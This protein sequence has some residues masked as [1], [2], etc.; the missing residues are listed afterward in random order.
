MAWDFETDREYQEKLDWADTFLREE[1][2]P[3]D[4]VVSATDIHN[5]LWQEVVPALQAKVKAQ[6]LWATHLGPELGGPGFGQ[7]KLALLN[8]ILGRS[9]LGPTVFGCAAPDTGNMEILAHYGTA[10]QKERWLKPLLDGEILSAYS[11]TEPQGGAD[12]TALLTTAELDGDEWVI[13]GEKWFTT[14][15][16]QAEFL[17]M[18]VVTDP[19]RC[20]SFRWTP[21]ASK[22]SGTSA[23]GGGPIVKAPRPT[24]G[25]ST[26]GYRGRIF[27]VSRARRLP[28][29]RPASAEAGST[30]LC[31]PSDR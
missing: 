21:L 15:A 9:G 11:M 26:H 2:E 3:L 12:P 7:V 23:Y 18:F 28:S 27:S 20:S 14:N 30:T 17:I 29:P 10:Q 1:V 8:E 13:N 5:P 19:D 6:G 4:F 31:A 25:W 22:S 16:V 24:S